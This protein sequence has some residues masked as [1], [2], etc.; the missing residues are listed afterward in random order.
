MTAA[1]ALSLVA[2]PS[3]SRRRL[4]GTL[5]SSSQ[6]PR[7]SSVLFLPCPALAGVPSIGSTALVS[8]G[9]CQQTP[10]IPGG[11]RTLARQEQQP[12]HTT[13]TVRGK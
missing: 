13:C 6:T 2:L 4:V 1:P 3:S 11:L 8:R 12:P 10:D 9:T 7:P 5:S